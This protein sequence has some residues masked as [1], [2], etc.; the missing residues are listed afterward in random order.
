MNPSKA[1]QWRREAESR[2]THRGQ[3]PGVSLVGTC[4]NLLSGLPALSSP[5]ESIHHSG[6]RA[7]RHTAGSLACPQVSNALC[8]PTTTPTRDHQA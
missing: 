8:L 2:W 6:W 3:A 4:H 7:L 5:L 1:V